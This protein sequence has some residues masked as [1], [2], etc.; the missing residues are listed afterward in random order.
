MSYDKNGNL[1]KNLHKN[2]STISY[3][4]LNLPTVITFTTGNT[5]EL[6][7]DAAGTKLCKT[8]KV[9]ATVQYVQDY[10]PGGIEYRQTGTGVKRVESVF[11]AEG[12]YYNTNVDASNTIAWRKEYN[13]KDHL[14]NTRLVFTDRNGNGIVDITGTASTSDVLQENHYYS[15]GLAFEGAWLQNDAG[16][17]DNKYGYNGKELNDD[18][19]LNWSD[20]G[21]RWYD[22]SIGRW[23]AVDP[24]ADHDELISWSPYNYANCNPINFIDPDGQNP[25]RLAIA[26]Y[27]YAKK[28]YK[29]YSKLEGKID[30][31]TPKHFKDAGIDELYD[32]AGD[33]FTAFG[34]NSSGWERAKAAVDIIIGTDFNKKGSKAVDKMLGE[35][36]DGAKG[37][38][39]N[40]HKSGKSYV[41]RGGK[42][43][44]K[45]SAGDKSRNEKDPVDEKESAY[46][47]SK[48]EDNAKE[49]EGISIFRSGTA[50]NSNSYNKIITG[51]K[52]INEE[53]GGGSYNPKKDY[54]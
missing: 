19:G 40:K 4:H 34:T 36:K 43:R 50:G 31:L 42:G 49:E 33:I 48:D 2:V 30:K 41:G 7:Y 24:L 38:Y 18:F 1:N 12:R 8:V 13:F 3:N 14:G 10:L 15:F 5:I 52:K 28:I 25:I 47:G 20:Y 44:Q 17:R 9:G 35:F 54:K 39:Y 53:F 22:G 46:Y 37:V 23:N 16:V 6:L 27:R 29:I 32:I 21:A 26:A 51:R 11:H 45:D